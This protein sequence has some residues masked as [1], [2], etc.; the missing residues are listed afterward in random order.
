M[1][2]NLN[3]KVAFATVAQLIEGL[4]D[5]REFDADWSSNH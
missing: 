1:T 5:G 3:P 4:S 2:T